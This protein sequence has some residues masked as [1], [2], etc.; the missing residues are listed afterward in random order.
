MYPKVNFSISHDYYSAQTNAYD[1][2]ISPQKRYAQL[3]SYV[4][5]IKEEIILVVHEQH[6][7]AKRVYAELEE[8]KTEKFVS[9]PPHT[10][11]YAIVTS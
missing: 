8:L 3:R 4:P 7:L 10:S 2:C 6:R 5:L 11:L 1:L 9:M